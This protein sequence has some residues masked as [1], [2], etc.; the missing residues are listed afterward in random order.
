MH[1]FQILM[2]VVTLAAVTFAA[3]WLARRVAWVTLAGIVALVLYATLRAGPTVVV[4]CTPGDLKAR[5]FD[6]TQNL[7]LFLPL[8]MAVATLR[9]TKQI[10]A[11]AALGVALSAFVEI[12]QSFDPTRCASGIDVVSNGL[13]AAMGA[14]IIVGAHALFAAPATTRH[15]S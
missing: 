13:G 15:P 8:G 5:V 3:S 9:S 2:T 4:N 11:S 12:A 10:A 6:V 14:V 7:I 1:R